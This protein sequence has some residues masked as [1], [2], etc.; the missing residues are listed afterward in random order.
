MT[1]WGQH[2]V[3]SPINLNDL[4]I[5]LIDSIYRTTSFTKVS[6]MQVSLEQRLRWTMF[7]KGNITK[8][9]SDFDEF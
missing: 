3:V 9:L 6:Q 5:H 8:L 4:N 7:I 1:Y 2:T